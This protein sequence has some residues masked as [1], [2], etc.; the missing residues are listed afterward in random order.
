MPLRT[1]LGGLWAVLPP[2]LA[3]VDVA[4]L[5]HVFHENPR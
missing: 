2:R 1:H 4:Q 3:D 5:E